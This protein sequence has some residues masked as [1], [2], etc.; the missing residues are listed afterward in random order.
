MGL[1]KL[2]TKVEKVDPYTVKFTLKEV[3]APFIQNMAMEYASILSAEYGDQLLKAGKAAD[4]NQFPVGT[5]PF[6]LPQLYERRD[7]PLRRQSDYWKPNAVRIS[8][9]SSRSRRTPVRVQKLKRDECQVMSYPRPAD[10]APLK[11]ESSLAMPSQP[12]FN[13]GYL[14]VQRDA[15][16]GRQGRSASGARH[17][18]QQEGD[19]RLRVPVAQAK[20]RH[21][22]DAADAMVL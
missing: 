2:I 16:A 15:Q 22:S 17:G 11:A 21:E 3:N 1:D 10:I 4:I 13:L 9:D 14:R 5:G 6:H 18:D 19:H 20:A 8:A 7:D 12:G